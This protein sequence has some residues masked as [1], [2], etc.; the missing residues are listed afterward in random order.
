[1]GKTHASSLVT[2]PLGQQRQDREGPKG[3]DNRFGHL[4]KDMNLLMV[5]APPPLPPLQAASSRIHVPRQRH[6]VGR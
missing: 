2:Y 5:T 6:R 3:F 1:M 4:Y